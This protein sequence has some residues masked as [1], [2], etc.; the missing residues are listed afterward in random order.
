[1]KRFKTRT[2]TQGNHLSYE[3]FDNETTYVSPKRV[4]LEQRRA[5]REAGRELIEEN[6]FSLLPSRSK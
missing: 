6:V 3:L 4:S 1:M 2:K 5:L